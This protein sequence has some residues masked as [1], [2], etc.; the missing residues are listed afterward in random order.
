[1]WAGGSLLGREIVKSEYGRWG[2]E[3]KE[4]ERNEN[5][6]GMLQSQE[7]TYNLLQMLC[8]WT[9]VGKILWLL[10]KSRL[11]VACGKTSL[12]NTFRNVD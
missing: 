4:K 12:N 3:K 2:K 7:S 1:M 10:E 6:Q 8:A 11:K 5:A 9:R